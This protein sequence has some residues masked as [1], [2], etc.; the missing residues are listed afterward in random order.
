[1]TKAA[2]PRSAGDDKK[3]R[4]LQAGVAL[5][6]GEQDRPARGPKPSLT[7]QRIAGSAVALADAEGLEAVSMSK[8][9]AAFDVSAMALYRYIPGKTELVELM[10]ESVLAD[11]PDL[12]T[13]GPGW[14][15]R[16]IA[17]AQRSWQVYQAH[18]WLIAATA[19]RRQVMGPNQLGWLDAALAAMEPTG[20]TAPQRHQVFLLL[21]GHVRSLAQ[22]L[23]D[24]DEDHNREWTRLTNELLTRQA[25]RFP[26]LTRAVADGAFA[27]DDID[28]LAFGLERILDGVQTLIDRTGPAS[29]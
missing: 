12:T 8:V 16:L 28:P 13:A 27:P 5:L 14:R 3:Q 17:W 9:A 15:P 6:W 11:V 1:M 25:D 23:V 24:F 19:M 7:P 22:Q 4:D 21:A 2:R 26:A 20:L 18:P 29:T 10:V